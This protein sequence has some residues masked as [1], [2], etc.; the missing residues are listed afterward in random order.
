MIN[1]LA[2]KSNEFGDGCEPFDDGDDDNGYDH[3][4]DDDSGDADNGDIMI[5]M[6]WVRRQ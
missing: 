3:N 1:I 6:S 4:D 5:M 2:C